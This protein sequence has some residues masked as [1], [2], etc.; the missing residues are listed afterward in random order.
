MRNYA[1]EIAVGIFVAILSVSIGFFVNIG[2][3]IFSVILFGVIYMMA[4]Q[5]NKQLGLASLKKQ[6]KSFIEPITFDQVGGQLHVKQ[7]LQEAL[8]FLVQRDQIAKR[9]IRLMKGILLTGPPGTGKTMLAKAA[10]NYTDSVFIAAS[11]SEFVEK[12]VGTGANRVRELFTKARKQAKDQNKKNA[13]V[14]IDEIDVIGGKRDGGQHREYDQTLNQ[15]LTELDGIYHNAEVNILLIAATNRKD[16]LDEALVRPGRFDRH[17]EVSLPDKKGRRHILE[18]H[19]ANKKLH[20]DVDFDQIAKDTYQFSG[21]QLEAV[22]NEAAIYTLR[23]GHE[24]ITRE[25][26]QAAIDKVLLGEKNN[27]EATYED[28]LRVARHELGHAI[29]AEVTAPGSVAQVVLT[30]RGGALGFV[31]HTPTTDKYLYTKTE[32]EGKIMVTLGGS[33]AEELFY[34]ERSTGS[35]GD[36][37]QAL[38]LVKTMVES[39]L[40]SVGIIDS[41]MMTPDRWNSITNQVLNELLMKT[42]QKLEEYYVIFDK[43]M[44]HLMEDEFVSGDNFRNLLLN[45]QRF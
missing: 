21:A 15:L 42:K 32:I 41:S 13:I 16:I 25:H 2:A 18:L 6:N 14:F 12:Y 11:G 33:V 1:K 17:I 24:R 23:D 29:M 9:G 4:T 44:P 39:G 36:F 3:G 26:V 7:E 43:T 34:G 37:D 22:M 20:E 35:K 30:P 28:K 45:N 19:A 38:Q 31:R 27:R 5:P 10:A 8:D 40:T